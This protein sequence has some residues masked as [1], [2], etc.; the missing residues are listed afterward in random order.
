MTGVTDFQT[1]NQLFNSLGSCLIASLI[2]IL[3][4]W[5]ELTAAEGSLR[6]IENTF[7]KI[8]LENYSSGAAVFSGEGAPSGNLWSLAEPIKNGN[9]LSLLLYGVCN[10]YVLFSI[11]DFSKKRTF[12]SILALALSFATF[13]LHPTLDSNRLS[14]VHGLVF[15]SMGLLFGDFLPV[16]PLVALLYPPSHQGATLAQKGV[17]LVY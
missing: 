6:V 10:L 7:S 11:A 12:L 15:L 1:M 8:Y 13:G 14:T 3:L 5:V 2:P 4:P 17:H 9:F 16:L